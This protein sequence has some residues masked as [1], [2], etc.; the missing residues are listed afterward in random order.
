LK[1][2]FGTYS[3]ASIYRYRM[4]GIM[5]IKNDIIRSRLLTVEQTARY[6]NLAPRTIYNGIHHKTKKP[7]PVRPKR[8]GGA[9][10]F[11]LREL[12]EYINQL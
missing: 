11:D 2:S 7:F 5:E 8:I 6:L 10:R 1:F 3:I 4:K 12:D 9:V